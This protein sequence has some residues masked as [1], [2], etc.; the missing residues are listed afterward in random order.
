MLSEPVY[1]SVR[2]SPDVTVTNM[3]SEPIQIMGTVSVDN[4]PA[5]GGTTT[6]DND[7]NG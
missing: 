6:P 5:S 7:Q 4:F 1:V 2:N 3:P